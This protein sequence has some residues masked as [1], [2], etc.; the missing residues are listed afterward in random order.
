[1]FNYFVVFIDVDTGLPLSELPSYF[2]SEK[3]SQTNKGHIFID[4]VDISK[5]FLVCFFSNTIY[6]VSLHCLRTSIAIIPQDP[7]LFTGFTFVCFYLLFYFVLRSLRY[8]LGFYFN[9]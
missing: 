1:L 7:T 4:D 8:N 3:E 6:V 5:S 9:N 2:S